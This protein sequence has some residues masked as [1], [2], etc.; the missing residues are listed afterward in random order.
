MRGFIRLI[1]RGGRWLRH[2]Q[3]GEAIIE[4]AIL[5][6]I[7]I[8]ALIGLT[9]LGVAIYTQF[10]VRIAAQAGAAYAAANGLNQSGIAGAMQAA[11]S[12]S[13][14]DTSTAS[15]SSCGCATTTGIASAT[16]GSSCSGGATAGTYVNVTAK[17]SQSTLISYP[18]LPSTF[19]FSSTA[20]VRTQ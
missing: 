19:Q 8:F 18:N 13:N 10:E 1:L 15:T 9:D 17:A 20:M 6:P 3:R 7:L 5:A 12:L 16:C 11:T 14:L 4:F 2:N